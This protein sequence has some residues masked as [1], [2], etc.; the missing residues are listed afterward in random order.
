[1][2]GVSPIGLAKIK[3]RKNDMKKQRTAACTLTLIAAMGLGISSESNKS[4]EKDH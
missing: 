3:K 1:M 2:N 4:I